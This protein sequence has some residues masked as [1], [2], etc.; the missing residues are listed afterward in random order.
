MLREFCTFSFLG[1][2]KKMRSNFRIELV[3]DI[4]EEKK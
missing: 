2:C 4:S 3:I 1:E